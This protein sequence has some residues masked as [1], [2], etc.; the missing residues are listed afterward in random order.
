[1]IELEPFGGNTFLMRGVP[2]SLAEQEPQV[3]VDDLLV[4]L[5]RCRRME[6]EAARERLA[7]KAACTAAV[8][9]GDVLTMAQMQALLDDLALLGD[10]PESV[11]AMQAN[12][13]G[14]SEGAM[15][16]FKLDGTGQPLPCF[17][18]RPDTLWGVTFMSLA[19]EH[20]IIPELVS[21]TE[22]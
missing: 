2:V 16:E 10:W 6:P 3:L 9:A 19:P 13:I 12:W 18:T 15:I 17:T 1:M 7:M 4:E 8:K 5:A 11:R 14:R 21:G 22:Y 20:P